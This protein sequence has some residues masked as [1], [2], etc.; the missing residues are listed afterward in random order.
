MLDL[1]DLYQ[2]PLKRNNERNVKAA[3]VMMLALSH[4]VIH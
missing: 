2:R 3:S 4:F 1:K